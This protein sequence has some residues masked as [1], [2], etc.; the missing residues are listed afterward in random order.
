MVPFLCYTGNEIP[1]ITKVP[2]TWYTLQYQRLCMRL[3]SSFK[4]LTLLEPQSRFGDK[5]LKFQIVCPLNGTACGSIGEW[6]LVCFFSHIFL[7]L[8]ACFLLVVLHACKWI[9]AQK[10][11]SVVLIIL[12]ASVLFYCCVLC[13]CFPSVGRLRPSGGTL[14]LCVPHI[15]RTSLRSGCVCSSR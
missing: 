5:L 1:G 9:K 11:T 4:F 14:T 6:S 3:Q 12:P 10:V 7:V 13:Q 8:F 2:G 15:L